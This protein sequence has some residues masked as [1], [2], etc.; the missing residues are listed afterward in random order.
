MTNP[1]LFTSTICA[2]IMH[3]ISFFK[4]NPKYSLLEYSYIFALITSII[5]HGLTH[6]FFKILDRITV[7]TVFFINIYLI[8]KIYKLTKNKYIIENAFIIM[9]I[10]VLMF[11]MT[12]LIDIEKNKK[13]KYIPHIFAHILISVTNIILIQEYS[14]KKLKI[15]G[16]YIPLYQKR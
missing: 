3:Y 13:I 12:K 9:I 7:V 2:I 8:N 16:S 11:F 1:L 10:S 5:N 6:I 4:Y 14:I 15:Q